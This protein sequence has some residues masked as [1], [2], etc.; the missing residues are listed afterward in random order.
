MAKDSGS[1][2][3]ILGG[4]GVAVYGYFQG[5]FSA[6][7]LA[8]ATTATAAPATTTTTA[9]TATTVVMPTTAP[10]PVATTTPPATVTPVPASG[11]SL[12]SMLSALQSVVAQNSSDPAFNGTGT[13]SNPTASCD[14][15]NFYL[16]QANVGVSDGMLDCSPIRGN[17]PLTLTAYW[18]W[19]APLLQ[20]KIP[21]LSGLGSVYA[22]LGALVRAQRGW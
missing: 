11:Q 22:G 4:L 20:Q 15:F 9:P 13:S 2:I 14:V 7:G 1:T 8:P 21:G 3:L 6:F 5:W 17:G 16:T 12:A 10:A 18:A 19:A